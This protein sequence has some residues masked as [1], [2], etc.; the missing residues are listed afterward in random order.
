MKFDLQMAESCSDAVLRHTRLALRD[1]RVT[2]S[3][4]AG[5]VVDRYL[6]MHEIHK[7]VVKF[8]EPVGDTDALFAAMKHNV[9]IVDRYL[10]GEVKTFPCDLVEA[11]TDA[12]PEPYRLNCQRELVRRLGFVGAELKRPDDSA[13]VTMGDVLKEFGD[14]VTV[15]GIALSGRE[16]S[17]AELLGFTKEIDDVVAALLSMKQ[18]VA[19]G[20]APGVVHELRPGQTNA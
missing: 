11:W 4:F 2:L 8:R 20:V 18:Q 13:H 16:L 5:E 15:S 7:R 17:R 1:N 14:F 9:Q 12:L 6:A 3:G 19:S 10:K